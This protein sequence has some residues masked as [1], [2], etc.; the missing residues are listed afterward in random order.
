[1]LTW[2][3][4]D[5]WEQQISDWGSWK[6]NLNFFLLGLK[7]RGWKVS[8]CY[9]HLWLWRESLSEWSNLKEICKIVPMPLITSFQPLYQVVPEAKHTIQYLFG[10]IWVEGSDTWNGNCP[11]LLSHRLRWNRKWSQWLIHV[12]LYDQSSSKNINLYNSCL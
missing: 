12:F 5:Q 4:Q 9:R 6:K 2:P 1:M 3:N 11:L 7:V 8:R 10:L